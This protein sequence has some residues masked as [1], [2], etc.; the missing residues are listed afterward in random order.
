MHD[1]PSIGSMTGS[2]A[3]CAVEGSNVLHFPH[4]H[5]NTESGESMA[6]RGNCLVWP[7]HG[8]DIFYSYLL[9]RFSVSLIQASF[10]IDRSKC[11]LSIKDG[12]HSL[13]CVE[14]SV[15][16]LLGLL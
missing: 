14:S 4:S 2:P 6:V 12:L 7:F 10:F 15:P 9:S 11:I 1:A 16:T 3:A 8:M 13:L 5:S